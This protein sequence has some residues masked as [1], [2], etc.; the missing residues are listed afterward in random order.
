M[1]VSVEQPGTARPGSPARRTAGIVGGMELHLTFDAWDRFQ[2]SLYER[3]D[4]LDL[5]EPGGTYAR[6]ER[7]DV[8]VLSAHAEAL[9]SQDID[10]DVWETLSDLDLE[11]ADEESGWA[12]I[13][14]FYLGRG[15]VLVRIGDGVSADDREEWIFSEGLSTRLRLADH[16]D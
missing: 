5:R 6:D 14:D 7:V 12:L 4:R 9:Y 13:R 8:W 11:A 1:G 2:E 3:G 16:A 15:G 10:P